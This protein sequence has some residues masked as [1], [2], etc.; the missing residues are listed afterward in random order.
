[1]R[2]GSVWV[3]AALVLAL[4]CG[5][6]AATADGGGG[7]GGDGPVAP[8][9]SEGRIEL[10]ADPLDAFPPLGEGT[11]LSAYFGSPAEINC[12]VI[13][14]AGPCVTSGCGFFLQPEVTDKD[15][16]GE[17]SLSGLFE[18]TATEQQPGLYSFGGGAT[19]WKPGGS[20]TV[21]ASGGVVP[22][23]EVTL[24]TAPI[25]ET[26]GWV[27]ERPQS[28]SEDFVA[29]IEPFDGAVHVQFVTSAGGDSTTYF[30]ECEL[31]GALGE[32]RIPAA[33]FAAIDSPEALADGSLFLSSRASTEVVAG[34]YA[35]A[36]TADTAVAWTR[37]VLS[38]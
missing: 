16:A 21:R 1:M 36:V 31:D 34:D 8:P 23:F 18:V 25:F 37:L 17:L 9:T 32:V 14:E 13:D 20:V 5:D 6:D 10:S 19:L 33:S 30:I 3:G 24:E 35:I 28:F 27:E 26:P 4:G 15:S 22:P 2:D 38:N 29:P 12:G 11:R 7:W